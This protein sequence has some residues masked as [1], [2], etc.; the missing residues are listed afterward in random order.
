MKENSRERSE[1]FIGN[2]I[3]PAVVKKRNEGTVAQKRE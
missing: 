1:K 2:K 3:R